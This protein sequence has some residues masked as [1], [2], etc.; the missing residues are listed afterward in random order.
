VTLVEEI[1]AGGGLLAS[2]L[3]PEPDIRPSDPAAAVAGRGEET[4]LAVDAIHEGYLLHY[5][6]AG[7]VLAPSEPDLALLAGDRL[8]AFGLDRLASV[9]DLHAVAQLAGVIGRCAE[10]HAASDDAAA[11]AAWEAGTVALAAGSGD[12]PG[13]AQLK[14]R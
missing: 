3:A 5:S 11:H 9:G 7:R 6:A 8:Y 14:R 2:A 1:R 10:A 4:A 13:A 12:G